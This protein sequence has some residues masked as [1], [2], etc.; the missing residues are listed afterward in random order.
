M[1]ATRA[2]RTRALQTHVDTSAA[3]QQQQP[4]PP[5]IKTQSFAQPTSK[6]QKRYLYRV[7]SPQILLSCRWAYPVLLGLGRYG[8]R[9]VAGRNQCFLHHCLGMIKTPAESVQTVWHIGVCCPRR[10]K[11]MQ[12]TQNARRDRRQHTRRHH[13]STPP[14]IGNRKG[15]G[16]AI[17]RGALSH[18][19][20]Y[21]GAR[22]PARNSGAADEAGDKAGDKARDKA[23]IL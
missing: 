16:Y 19:N 12:K 15:V 14:K 22:A 21:S 9:W 13:P 11:K 5:T 1:L 17:R 7:G 8:R 6:M 3:T 23:E 2:S 4:A 18:R 20:G 10:C